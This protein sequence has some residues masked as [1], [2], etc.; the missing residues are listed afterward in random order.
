MSTIDEVRACETTLTEAFEQLAD[1]EPDNKEQLNGN[2]RHASEQYAAAVRELRIGSHTAF[3][4]CSACDKPVS[5]E[6]A[7]TDDN[8]QAVHEKCYLSRLHISR[9]RR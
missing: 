2:V 9:S 3:P 8:G 5:L 6:S 7:N 1:A 4:T